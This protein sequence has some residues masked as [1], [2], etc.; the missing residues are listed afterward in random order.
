MGAAA[1][2]FSEALEYP[3]DWYMSDRRW[4][5]FSS[6]N[7]ACAL[8]FD[9]RDPDRMYVGDFFTVW[10]SDDGGR[11][12]RACPRG[13]NTLC[14]YQVI[15]DPSDRQTLYVNAA[16]LG[17]FR[18]TDGGRTFHWPFRYDRGT[19]DKLINETSRLLIAAGDPRRLAVTMTIDWM[20]P[21][22]NGCF[23]SEDRGEHWRDISDGL[24][25]QGSFM[26]GMVACDPELRELLVACG[27]DGQRGGDV[28]R[29]AD[30]GATWRPLAPGLPQGRL[31][32]DNWSIMP[33]LTWDGQWV[34]A[35]TSQGLYR[36]DRNG[37]VWRRIG[38]AALKGVSVRTIEALPEARGW[39]WVGTD[40]GLLVSRDGGDSFTRLSLDGMEMCQ[41]VAVDR[42]SP[43]RRWFVAV[44]A[45][46]WT[47]HR[48][49]PGIWLTEDGGASY[50]RLSPMPGEGMA[51]RLTL[52][53]HDANRLYVGTNGIG[54][55]RVT[56]GKP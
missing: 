13:L 14:V 4:T 22:R 26:T 1:A 20:N 5:P 28:Y 30:G 41:G 23:L 33:N 47:S 19:G 49:R 29:T 34:Y 24:P 46:W 36:C 32:G 37:G 43:T 27:G 45:P 56:L 52:D 42:R 48:N 51:W 44:A 38:E 53:P 15:P 50:V 40:H 35:A 17:L 18:S 55:W 9:P 6:M 11:H 25:R 2:R 31:F 7:G 3:A 54:A 39:L 8:A 21:I 10:R 12:F 16:D